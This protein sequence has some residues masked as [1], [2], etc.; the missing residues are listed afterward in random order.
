MNTKRMLHY[1]QRTVQVRGKYNKVGD[2]FGFTSRQKP[3]PD[4]S[5]TL[6]VRELYRLGGNITRYTRKILIYV[7]IFY[8]HFIFLDFWLC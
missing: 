5:G 7:Y 1:S 6:E 4:R 2:C 8:Q 3:Y